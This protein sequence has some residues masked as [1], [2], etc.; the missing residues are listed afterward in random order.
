MGRDNDSRKRAIALKAADA[1]ELLKA[2]LPFVLKNMTKV[3]IDQIQKVMDA[4]VVNPVI[5][6]EANEMLRK[7]VRAQSGQLV[8]YDER[9]RDL[10]YRHAATRIPVTPR[11]KRVRL[12][13]KKLL[14]E[15]ALKP[16]TD[17]PDEASYL[18][19]V[20]HWLE[21]KGVW[22]R[23][24]FKLVRHPEGGGKWMIDPRTFQVWLSFGPEGDTIPTVDGQITREALL[25]TTAIGA[26]YWDHVHQGPV[27]RALKA[28]I[29]ILENQIRDG[30]DEH[31]RLIKRKDDAAPGV[32]EVSDFLGGADLPS[33]SIWDHP[34][35]LLVKALEAM[36]GG[37]VT[38]CQPYLVVAAIITR[39]NAQLLAQYIED[40]VSGAGTAVTILKVAKTAGEVAEVG[41]TVVSGVGLV[42]AGAKTVGKKAASDIAQKEI[43][44]A[45]EKLVKE[46]IRKDPSIA[47]DLDK[48]RWVPGPKGTVSGGGRRRKTPGLGEGF[49]RFP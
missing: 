23:I 24:D 48:V 40:S 27:Q 6:Q 45:A 26:G 5:E 35:R 15:N 22:L 36:V 4:A 31:D 25:K 38:T 39:N 17:N 8:M 49:D 46:I 13:V 28:Q 41:L 43:D 44:D 19:A 18:K 3:Q 10:A 14:A 34:H 2:S 9:K 33:R 16:T 11:D 7:S 30:I 37:N 42:R 29:R 32:A 1:N 12:D 47:N 21:E 20:G